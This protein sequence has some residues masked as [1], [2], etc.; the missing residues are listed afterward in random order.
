MQFRRLKVRFRKDWRK[1]QKQ[2]ES[3]GQQAETLFEKD[4]FRRFDRLVKVRR[5]VLTWTLLV[6]LLIG[7]VVAETKGLSGYYQ[8]LQPAP[9]GIFTEGIVGQYT[10]A[11]PVYATSEVDQ[12]VSHLIFAGL[13]TYNSQNRL[14]GNLADSWQADDNGQQYLVHLRP[15]LTWQDGRPLTAADVVFTFHVI[16]NPDAQSPF[17]ASWQGVTITA[18]DSQTVL[19]TLPNPL[20]SFPYSLTTGIIPQHLLNNVP[21]NEMRS[22]AFNTT[23]PIGAG[24]FALKQLQVTGDTPQTHEEQVALRPFTNYWAG[25]PKLDS[26]VI[27]AFGGAQ[28]MQNS[29]NKGNINAMVGLD[30]TPTNLTHNGSVDIYQMPL[31]A[32]NYVF[33]KTSEGVLSDAKVRQALIQDSNVSSIINQLDYPT[34]P[35][36]EPLL[37]S[38]LGYNPSYRQAGYNPSAA[39][40]TLTADGWVPG[41]DGIRYKNGLP[42]TFNLFAQNTSEYTMV[43]NALSQAWHNLGVDMHVYLQSSTDLQPTLEAHSYDALLDAVSIGVDPDVYVYWDSTQAD[44]RAAGRLNFSEYQSATADTSLEAG[45][46][47]TDPAL[48][49]IKYQPLLQAWQNDAPALGL[50]QPRFLYI[51]R[52]QVFGL[53]EHMINT[54]VDRYDNVQNWEIRQVPTT[55]K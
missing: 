24:P 11:N 37:R 30:S 16:Q 5:F 36:D 6:F 13:L 21:M 3:F 14:V 52:G 31:T 15:H 19:F 27:H 12:A 22:V 43:T 25:D 44:I 50:Y 46:T 42:L 55:I 49:A 7:S 39:A 41:K 33:F 8:T 23:S 35:V 47:R 29:F 51:S 45:R 20:A 28:P 54:D 53:S 32:A 18:V 17:S 34:M 48:R 4:F 38:Q 26:F 2:V 10:N 9:G 40:A 1:R